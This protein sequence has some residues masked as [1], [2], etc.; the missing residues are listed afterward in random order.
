MPTL[1]LQPAALKPL[2]QYCRTMLLLL[3][4]PAKHAV[5]SPVRT[6]SADMSPKLRLI[7]MYTVPERVRMA[8]MICP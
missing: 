5:L 7:F 8:Y 1:L 2:L 3:F 6:C 4:T